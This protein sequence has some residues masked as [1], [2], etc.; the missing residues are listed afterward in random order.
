M[1]KILFFIL[2]GFKI[3]SFGLKIYNIHINGINTTLKE[4]KIN[5]DVLENKT[6]INSNIVKWDLVYNPSSENPEET[7]FLSNISDTIQQKNAELS[8][9]DYTKIYIKSFNLSEELYSEG[10]NNFML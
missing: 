5:Q 2:V 6:Q 1:K 7:N 4:A 8:L 10:L 3:N 9:D